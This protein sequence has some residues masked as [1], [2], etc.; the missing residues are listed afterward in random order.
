M[1]TSLR[2]GPVVF[3]IYFWWFNKQGPHTHFPI[4]NILILNHF[5]TKATCTWFPWLF[6]CKIPNFFIFF[7][8]ISKLLHSFLNLYS[9]F[10][11]AYIKFPTIFQIPNQH[12]KPE[13]DATCPTSERVWAIMITNLFLTFSI[14]SYFKVTCHIHSSKCHTCADFNIN[15]LGKR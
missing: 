13:Q 9:R 14:R 3:D 11:M 6:R 5:P 12:G 7:F 15:F 4:F 8:K 1:A 10:G 2:Q